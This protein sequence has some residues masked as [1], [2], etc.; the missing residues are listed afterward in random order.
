MTVQTLH[1]FKS[2]HDGMS[3]TPVIV[4]TK[5]ESGELVVAKS[6]DLTGALVVEATVAAPVGGATEAKQDDQITIL[7]AIDALVGS[8]N[9][10]LDK[11]RKWPYANWDTIRQTWNA[12]TF[13]KTFTYKVGGI[14]GTTVG[15]I[16]LVY[17]D[18]TATTLDYATYNPAQAV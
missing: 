5:N 3:I 1:Q 8:T 9:S 16:A 18:V 2:E 7:N 15:T 14:G 12:G 17:T 10:T 13:T 4:F 11:I 6:N